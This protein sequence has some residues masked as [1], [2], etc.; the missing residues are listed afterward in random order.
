[1]H[2]PG[3]AGRVEY[4]QLLHDAS[5]VTREV[6]DRVRA[7]TMTDEPAQPSGTLTLRLPVRRPEVEIPVIEM[8]LR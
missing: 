1:M 4:A 6:H 2:L 5:E 3:L 7:A 8:F